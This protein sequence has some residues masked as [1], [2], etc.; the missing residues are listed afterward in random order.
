M[1]YEPTQASV[2]MAS[3]E[4]GD[5]ARKDYKNMDEL[6][7]SIC[8][9]GLI[10]PITVMRNEDG[11]FLLLAG[12]RRFRAVKELKW[13]QV[14]CNIY[15][16]IEDLKIRRT[17]ELKENVIRENLNYVEEAFLIRE[18][19]QLQ[20]EINGE[21]TAGRSTKGHSLQDTADLLNVSRG[22]V[23]AE[24]EIANALEEDP[25]LA[26]KCKTK[27]DLT[28]ALAAK[29]E[30]VLIA[31]M[32]K[33]ATAKAATDVD[34]TKQRLISSFV[35]TDVDEALDKF[36]AGT[37]NLVEIDPPY[38]IPMRHLVEM[39]HDEQAAL[40]G[41]NDEMT[42]EQA[43]AF[44]AWIASIY[45]K[46]F[47][48]L[49]NDGWLISWLAI[50]PWLWSF[51]QH[52]LD[53]GFVGTRLPAMWVKNIG[54]T[55]T[56]NIHLQNRFEPILYMRKGNAMLAKPGVGNTFVFPI[57]PHKVHP[58][59]KPIEL[60]MD[61]LRT[62]TYPGASVLSV[63]TGSGNILLAAN[64]VNMMAIG[65]DKDKFN[66]DSF[67]ARVMRGEPGKYTSY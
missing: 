37:F 67:T 27:S 53:A 43:E 36:E 24:I 8:T 55:R 57:P 1:I 25:T 41:G 32:A 58:T 29:K 23:S 51:H 46:A 33:R 16:Y 3:I 31:E 26:T 13:E 28:K 54:N 20:V 44:S 47:R 59:E 9:E 2:Q 40:L 5:R 61:L 66:K 15:P 19:H 38:G 39:K 30:A 14:S 4:E 10:N 42:P 64:N 34:K 7:E 48:V 11:T 17:I 49:K 18:I 63:F 22:T 12:G 35:L 45:K 50:D 52:A 65:L 21:A 62:F 60:Y 6:K 56:P